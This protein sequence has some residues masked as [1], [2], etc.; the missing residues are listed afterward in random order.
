MH[1]VKVKKSVKDNIMH[2][3]KVKKWLKRNIYA[4]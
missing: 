2:G 1:S 4:R 3:I